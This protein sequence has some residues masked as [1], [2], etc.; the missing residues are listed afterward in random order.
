MRFGYFQMAFLRPESSLAAEATECAADQD[1]FWPYHDR[2][3][4]LDTGS[5]SKTGLIQLARELDLDAV[6]FAECLDSGKHTQAIQD[7]L[8]FT[9]VIGARS[10]PSFLVNGQAIVGAQSF[11]VF[12]QIIEQELQK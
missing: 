5:M 6:T 11:E 4:E 12:Q 2:V 9:R 10:T 7:D 1:A 8:E 3:F